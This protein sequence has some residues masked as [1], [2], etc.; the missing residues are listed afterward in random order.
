MAFRRKRDEWDDFLSRAGPE[1]RA[2]LPDYVVTNK[3]RFLIFLDHGYDEG[4]V[5]EN[6]GL[7]FHPD[8][9]SDDQI[10]RLADL[11]GRHMDARYAEA[12]R[13]RWRHTP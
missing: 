8:M 13:S 2:C 3:P 9:M 7:F 5:A 1:L 6:D 4:G 11:L 10:A 12:V